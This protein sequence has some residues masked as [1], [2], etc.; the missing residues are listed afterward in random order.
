MESVKNDNMSKP[1][2]RLSFWLSVIFGVGLALSVLLNIILFIMVV[3]KF[4]TMSGFQDLQDR[5]Y[6]ERV[7]GGETGSDNK[8]LLLPISGVIMSG[9]ES[10]GFW[11]AASDPVQTVRDVLKRAESDRYVKAII[12]DINSPGGGVTASDN[13]HRELKR[14]KAK[15][16]DVI[17]VSYLGEV[18]ASGGY[19]VA[20]PSNRIVVHPTSITGSIGVIASMLNVEGLFQKIGLRSEVIKSADKKDIFSGTRP[21]TKEE[22][23]IMQA[24]IDEMYHRFVGIVVEGRPNLTRSEIL[25]LADGRIYT[26][27]QAVKNGLADES[28]DR[29]DAFEA[30]KKLAK[31][32]DA[33]LVQYQ[34]RH[35]FWEIFEAAASF[36]PQG[37]NDNIKSILLERNTPHLLYLWQME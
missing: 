25:K 3:A 23:A 21:M 15:R 11:G 32:A 27:E 17:I 18:A 14:F 34:K 33:R 29:E 2:S 7:V 22:R 24:M 37:L 8:I 30:A 35:D 9:G 5:R 10:S 26:G 13:I 28:G 6:R 4:S 12:L 20:M 31:I 16:P 1:K 36:Q 19:Y